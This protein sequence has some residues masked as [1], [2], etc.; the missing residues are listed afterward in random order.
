MR[1][2]CIIYELITQSFIK[3]RTRN[4]SCIICISNIYIF[5]SDNLL[6]FFSIIFFSIVIVFSSPSFE[7]ARRISPF[8]NMKLS[9]K[10][11]L[12]YSLT[13]AK[14]NALYTRSKSFRCCI[15]AI[16]NPLTLLHILPFQLGC[17]VC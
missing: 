10:N 17:S 6:R 15:P 12:S 4:E 7:S 5:F 3:L 8:R 2:N 13:I 11:I 16:I 9:K 14:M 1:I